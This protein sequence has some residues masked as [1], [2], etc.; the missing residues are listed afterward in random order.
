MKHSKIQQFELGRQT[1]IISLFLLITSVWIS[2]KVPPVMGWSS[3][4][5]YRVNISDSLIMRQA[6]AMRNSPL[7]DAGYRYVNIDDGYFGGRDSATGR[8]RIHPVRFPGGMRPVVEH[9][10]S[11]GL[12]AG[13][14]SDA[15]TSTCG[16][17][18]DQDSIAS[19]VGLNGHET[20]DCEFFFNDLG[21]DFIKVDFCGGS[22]WQNPD[23]TAL[24]PETSYCRIRKA[25]DATGRK[26]L[27][28]NVC[29]W[30]YPGTWVDKVGASWR[31][32]HDISCSWNSVKDI[33]EQN[34]YLSAFAG[35]GY[36]DMDMLE[37]GRTL[38]PEEDRTHFAMWCIMASPLLIG[39]DL[40]TVRPE[41]MQLLTN[42]D[43]IAINQDRLGKQA[44][45]ADMQGGTY[46]LVKDVVEAN[47][48]ERAVALYNPE[49]APKSIVLRFRDVDLGGKIELR[50]LMSQKDMGIFTDSIVVTVPAHGVKIYRGKAQKRLERRV[51]EA[52]TAYLTAYQ[53]L[54][55]P[56]ASGSPFREKD[57]RCSGGIR[58]SNLGSSPRNDLQWR[59]VYSEEGGDYMAEFR[60]V[61]DLESYFLVSVNGGKAQK[62]KVG[63]SGDLQSVSIDV[64]LR[65]GNNI[66][67]LVNDRGPM[68]SIDSMILRKQK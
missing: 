11:L 20:E 32:S 44:Y 26:D 57:E 51:Y 21:F 66:I 68:P 31:I 64:R 8:L 25:M 62:I 58:I 59:E 56:F 35:D 55:N 3:W 63:K 47:G 46:V 52:E 10:H 39:C 65:P 61:S 34:L 24:D 6:S 45:V 7:F 2:A 29:R 38:T 53:E 15:G 16:Y 30:D 41:T 54:Y 5:T 4:N 19:N 33:I 22:S 14:Y 43:L 49:D 28:M 60:V 50:D 9:I 67:R 48:S 27:R 17:F 36:N 23:M 42:A 1:V 13:I 40:T 18:Y 37:V 12:K